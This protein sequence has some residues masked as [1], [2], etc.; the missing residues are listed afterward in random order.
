VH[1]TYHDVFLARAQAAIGAARSV[2]SVSHPALKGHLREI[3]VRTL[4][5]PLLPQGI[6]IGSGVII[7][8]EG[9]TSTQ[10][11]IILY[12][13]AVV[14]PAAFEGEIGMF[15]VESVLFVLE[16]KSCLTATDLKTAN[17]S[18]VGL[19]RLKHAA[20]FGRDW[21]AGDRVEGC[22]PVLFAF[23]S[24]LTAVGT[25][26]VERYDGIRDVSR[27]PSI[28]GICVADRGS[29]SWDKTGWRPWPSG[30]SGSEILGM[31]VGITNA[32]SRVLATRRRPDLAAYLTH[33][34]SAP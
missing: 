20:P 31:L 23:D 9:E 22:I 29:W 25:T 28:R 12:D 6:G 34:V 24:D 32:Y 10:Q 3:L 16:V 15:P 2:S 4:L 8:A 27:E 11:D 1:S 19:L 13:A 7:S 26:E 21:E 17:D 5:R 18:A 33:L 30:P 14:P